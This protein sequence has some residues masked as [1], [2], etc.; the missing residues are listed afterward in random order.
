MVEL[1]AELLD[2]TA[3]YASVADAVI[4]WSGREVD[5]LVV[6]CEA[7]GPAVDPQLCGRLIEFRKM[8]SVPAHNHPEERQFCVDYNRMIRDQLLARHGIDANDPE[9]V[10]QFLLE[11]SAKTN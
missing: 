11:E 1:W 6:A 8:L 9:Q 3:L 10:K 4:V 2:R 7:A 5:R